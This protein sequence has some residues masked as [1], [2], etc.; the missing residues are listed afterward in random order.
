MNVHGY[1]KTVTE[2]EHL[3]IRLGN[4]KKLRFRF[5]SKGLFLLFIMNMSWKKNMHNLNIY[6][7]QCFVKKYSM[8]GVL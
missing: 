4:T 1:F 7:L 8:C 5:K 3:K 2:K 6:V